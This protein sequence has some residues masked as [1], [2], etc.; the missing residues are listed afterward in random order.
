MAESNLQR[1][2]DLM[3]QH[4]QMSDPETFA[5]KMATDEGR[6]RAYELMS[7][8]YS[9]SPYDEFE[10]KILSDFIGEDGAAAQLQ[11]EQAERDDLNAWQN[12][13]H[14]AVQEAF[15]SPRAAYA[16]LAGNFKRADQIMEI[17]QRELPTEEG[18]AAAFVGG[19][20]GGSASFIAAMMP[21]FVPGAQGL[22]AIT[23]P[24]MMVNYG[25]QAAG[26]GRGAVHGF[27][28]RTGEDISDWGEAAVAAG[29]GLAVFASEKIG[30]GMLLK[31][32]IGKMSRKALLEV[33]KAWME[34]GSKAAAKIIVK[35]TVKLAPVTA[36]IEGGE[37]G[38]EQLLTNAIDM[39]YDPDAR[40]AQQLVSGVPHATAA[41]VIGGLTL[42][43][44]GG[45]A[46]GI[47]GKG[48]V[49]IAPEMIKMLTDEELAVS[50]E[51]VT[52][53]EAWLER[54]GLKGTAERLE[55]QTAVGTWRKDG[56]RQVYRLSE[57]LEVDGGVVVPWED[58]FRAIVG[59]DTQQD[60]DTEAEAKRFVEERQATQVADLSQGVPQIAKF[61]PLV[62]E[63][64]QQGLNRRLANAFSNFIIDGDSQRAR[65]LKIATDAF[66]NS[67]RSV[68]SFRTE[69][70]H[71]G[72][73]R[74]LHEDGNIHISLREDATDKTVLHEMVHAATVFR[75]YDGAVNNSAEGKQLVAAANKL[76][77]I[78][79]QRMVDEM[80]INEFAR[81]Y[82]AM[83]DVVVNGDKASTENRARF[84]M[85]GHMYGLYNEK[86]FVSEALSNQLFQ[87]ALATMELTKEEVA[88]L[89]IPEAKPK[90][91]WEAIKTVFARAFGIKAKDTALEK[92]YELSIR[93]I[94]PD[95]KVLAES[96]QLG[97]DKAA[98]GRVALTKIKQQAWNELHEDV[99]STIAQKHAM[100]NVVEILEQLDVDNSN[101]AKAMQHVRDA[102]D[103]LDVESFWKRVGAALSGLNAKLYYPRVAFG[104]NMASNT[105]GSIF[106]HYYKA[107]RDKGM[108][109]KDAEQ[110]AR[111]LMRD[112]IY[113]Y[114][115]KDKLS[116]MSKEERAMHEPAIE[117][118]DKF[119]EFWLDK[120]KHF[121]VFP[122]GFVEGRVIKIEDRI[123]ELQAEIAKLEQGG[124][125]AMDARLK[126]RELKKELR[127]AKRTKFIHIP[128]EIVFAK[129]N[130][131]K[132]SEAAKEIV[133]THFSS[134]TKGR[135]H[136][137]LA[138]IV[139]NPK[140]PFGKNDLDLWDILMR[141]SRKA[142]KDIATAQFVRALESEGLAAKAVSTGPD[143]NP[144]APF[145]LPASKAELGRP[146][147]YS[148][149]KQ[150]YY[151]LPFAKDFLIDIEKRS[152][153]QSVLGG[154]IS[155]TLNL[156]KMG[157][158]FNPF[159][160]PMYDV[161]QGVMAGS[162]NPLRPIRSGKYLY[163]A[164]HDFTNRTQEWYDAEWWGRSST[165]FPN[166][167]QTDEE[168]VRAYATIGG[169]AGKLIREMLNISPYVAGEGISGVYPVRLL[170]ATY[171]LSWKMAW[172][173]DSVLR[174]ATYRYGLDQGMSPKDA[175][176][177]AALFHGDYAGVPAKTRKFLNY[178]LFTPTFKVAMGKM[179]S[180]MLRSVGETIVPEVRTGEDLSQYRG[181][182][183]RMLAILGAIELLMAALGFESDQFGRRYFR[184]TEID[185]KP[186]ETAV[187]YSNPANMFLK[188]LYRLIDAMGPEVDNRMQR[189]FQS[190]IWEL[191]PIHRVAQEMVS[192]RTANG[193]KIVL[194]FDPS[195]LRGGDPVRE[196]KY[197]KYLVDN[198]VPLLREVRG[199]AGAQQIEGIEDKKVREQ[200]GKDVSKVFAL[201]S[202]PFTYA[203]QRAP[204]EV[205][206]RADVQALQRFFTEDVRQ[207]VRL[208]QEGDAE[209]I[210]RV[211]ELTPVYQRAFDE[212]LIRYEEAAVK[213]VEKMDT[214]SP[215]Q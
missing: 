51:Y 154:T 84:N 189:F 35:N 137:R 139:D 50:E 56:P 198:L 107:M 175:A 200:L 115:N 63:E 166:P 177:Q 196:V 23:L 133:K 194:T 205:R 146:V 90:N 25:L 42:G 1:A 70:K 32:P 26:S 79:S 3:S 201:A 185:G 114:E 206:M 138:D 150:K 45:A 82:D 41:G 80:G 161:V 155:K 78:V 203:Y 4:Y 111:T 208:V 75:L 62:T 214:G 210:K 197:A 22:A 65:L 68:L 44:A 6:Q 15:Y 19:A 103:N 152:E 178:F 122:V 34:G 204:E 118:L 21:A 158:F 13:W 57:G 144:K 48:Y 171:N 5:S 91:V 132:S 102:K 16:Q 10:K 17:A 31:G 60:F 147:E 2:Y 116:N 86:E 14:S 167:L 37:E 59:V 159:F 112:L 120:Y 99:R 127:R 182:F 129:I 121:D 47:A 143:K 186:V 95:V 184:E 207:L 128:S 83:E 119:F 145:K 97:A 104:S 12:F 64:E 188:Y 89:R 67:N 142:S 113:I 108:S 9:M 98:A 87:K 110:A 94:E 174:Q 39:T 192:N 8:H 212:L 134:A 76:F 105:T 190:N 20:M 148:V 193:D 153:R 172:A 191:H 28:K 24:A 141:Y 213:D 163:Q 123:T 215:I 11:V 125:S 106:K 187:T 58:G 162:I 54:K 74:T 77:Q 33:N 157:Q 135:V 164:I 179:Y 85:L 173:M 49:P 168:I 52:A 169:E 29:Y 109:M 38:L 69:G 36:G 27:E 43:L 140:I 96:A 176:Q 209:A 199:F 88:Q 149:G 170:R 136:L 195:I 71:P 183:I 181:S 156:T 46:Q 101:A 61:D 72:S 117:V 100:K 130:E 40:T 160:L 53:Y 73:V 180:R 66:N 151:M 202:K 93:L 7:A 92:A 211:Q 30:L 55:K 18:S 124:G 126:I 131:R 165:P 81:W